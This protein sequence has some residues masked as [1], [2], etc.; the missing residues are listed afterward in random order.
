MIE[1]PF[2]ETVRMCATT[3]APL[4]GGGASGAVAQ[5]PHFAAPAPPCDTSFFQ[6]AQSELRHLRATQTS[7]ATCVT[8][9]EAENHDLQAQ[10]GGRNAPIRGRR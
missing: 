10:A 7:C 9:I 3:C 4:K 8:S 6:V 5:T 2:R 1:A